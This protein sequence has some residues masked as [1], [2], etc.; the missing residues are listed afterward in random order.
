M[1]TILGQISFRELPKIQLSEIIK[2]RRT[3]M[4][5]V[6]AGMGGGT[7]TGAAP[8]I[9]KTARELGILTVGVITKPFLPGEET[10][11]DGRS[12]VKV[13]LERIVAAKAMIGGYHFPFPAFGRVAAQDNGYAFQPLAIDANLARS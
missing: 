2:N 7:G 12:R 1:T 10:F 13:T 3:H 6:T 8:I 5:F 4:A 11:S 9:A